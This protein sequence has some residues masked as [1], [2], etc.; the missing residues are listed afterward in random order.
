VHLAYLDESQ[1]QGAVAIFGAVLVPH[2]EFGMAERM[3]SIAIEQLFAPDE[4][5]EKFQEFHAFELFKGEGAFKGI[6]EK[7]RFDAIRILLLTLRHSKL[8]FIYAAIDEKQLAKSALGNSL[9]ETADPLVPAFK[10]CTLGVEDWARAHHPQNVPGTVQ[11]DYNDQYLL[12]ADDTKNIE[13]KKRLRHSYRLLRAA[14]PY[15]LKSPRSAM[16]PLSGSQNRLWHAHDAIYFGDSKESVGIQLADLCTY[17][18]Q[19]QLMKRDS[20][21]KDDGDQFYEIFADQVVCAKPE[22]EWSQHRELLM[23]HK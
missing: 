19:R 20:S 11:I 10:L 18:M 12:I 14:R 3:H 6:D 9:F 13:L 8:P 1:Q 16:D 21:A 2:G 4:V 23:C 5:E 7:K 15:I 22:P 17:F